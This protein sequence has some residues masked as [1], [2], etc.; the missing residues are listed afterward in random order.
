MRR[1]TMTALRCSLAGAL[2]LAST[3]AVF[4][5]DNGF[6][7]GG[8]LGEAGVSYT[9]SNPGLNFSA[10]DTGYKLIAGFRP[11]SLLAVEM[12]YVDL[13]RPSDTVAG[14][15]VDFKTTGVDG[16]VVGFLPLPLPLVD[17]FAKV[18]EI[19]WDA[20]ASVPSLSLAAKASGNTLA[21]GAGGQ[22]HF[23]GVGVRLEY[24]RFNVKN[25]DKVDMIS[26]GVTWTFL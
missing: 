2:V 20:K 3:T 12:N 24:E 11:V 4:A 17:V 7:F 5:A 14:T 18:G 23:E 25:T 26:V 1:A 13:G 16:F 22:V 6:Y 21:Y 10:H 9:G 8:S 19:S 15:R